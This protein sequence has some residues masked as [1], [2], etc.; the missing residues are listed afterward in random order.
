MT[1]D[2]V[3]RERERRGLESM[4]LCMIQLQEA[5]R[6]EKS[7]NRTRQTLSF[8]ALLRTCCLM[9]AHRGTFSTGSHF[10]QWAPLTPLTCL[11]NKIRSFLN[12][13]CFSSLSTLC[14]ISLQEESR[15][16]RRHHNNI[17]DQDRR[18]KRTKGGKMK[19]V[20]DFCWIFLLLHTPGVLSLSTRKLH[21]DVHR[22]AKSEVLAGEEGFGLSPF[23]LGPLRS[24]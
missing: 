12:P 21:T 6:R 9:A 1:G 5:L 18:S 8:Y 23:F 15:E 24:L 2:C 19:A 20:L 3:G 17:R 10:F 4:N 11:V 22:C 14:V 7:A 16:K 13:G